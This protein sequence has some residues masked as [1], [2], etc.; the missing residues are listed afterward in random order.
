MTARNRRA[1]MSRRPRG[2]RALNKGCARFRGAIWV[3]ARSLLAE[4]ASPPFSR[5]SLDE[6]LLSAFGAK[7][8]SGEIASWK[9]ERLIK[10]VQLRRFRHP[11][12]ADQCGPSC[13]AILQHIDAVLRDFVQ[14]VSARGCGQAHQVCNRRDRHASAGTMARVICFPSD[15]TAARCSRELPR[16][17]RFELLAEAFRRHC[18][19]A[20]G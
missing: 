6:D 5:H 13:T 14:G 18:S 4:K 16:W 9:R 19:R 3:A 11:P 20:I 17:R 2:L 15:C 7:S 12:A 1:S 10:P 8:A